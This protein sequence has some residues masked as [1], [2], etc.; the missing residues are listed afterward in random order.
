[1]EIPPLTPPKI[2]GEMKS[3]NVQ[4]LR[5]YIMKINNQK[6][7][8][9]VMVFGVFDR[10]HPGHISFLEQAAACGD[11]LIAVVTRDIIVQ[12][13]KKKMPL[14]KEEERMQAVKNNSCVHNAVLGDAALGLYDV[15]R[16]RAPDI[17]CLGYD[18]HGLAQDLQ[19]RMAYGEIASVKLA[20][21]EPYN[22]DT[23]HTSLLTDVQ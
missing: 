5:L 19:S 4:T 23:L 10:L 12:E 9:K 13:L 17:I 7:P 3:L 1:M 2:G 18:Q 11:E 16:E 8:K 20:V 6:S 21:M 22:A 14:H 15:I